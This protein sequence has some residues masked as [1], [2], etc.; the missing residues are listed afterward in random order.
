MNPRMGASPSFLQRFA[1]RSILHLERNSPGLPPLHQTALDFQRYIFPFPL[2][3][4]R[5]QRR[6]GRGD[7]TRPAATSGGG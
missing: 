4:E 3:D 6:V 1:P 5:G 2:S 7:E